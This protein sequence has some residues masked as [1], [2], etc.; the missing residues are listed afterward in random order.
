MT[1]HWPSSTADSGATSG[2]SREFTLSA[3]AD[4]VYLKSSGATYARIANTPAS[5]AFDNG[6][7]AYY[8][9]NYWQKPSAANGWV[10]KVPK[11]DSYASE[12]WFD[13]DELGYNGNITNIYGYYRNDDDWISNSAPGNSMTS[14]LSGC[15]QLISNGQVTSGYTYRFKITCS[16]KTK[17]FWFR[18]A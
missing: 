10:C 2:P 12:E 9:S 18:A 16:G 15:E 6:W 3:D 13:I 4:Y 17:W 11:R 7:Y 8:D 5:D 14:F 1:V